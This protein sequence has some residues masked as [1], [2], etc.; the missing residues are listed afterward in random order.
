[1]AQIYIAYSYVRA[2]LFRE[3]RLLR[4]SDGGQSWS[5]APQVVSQPPPSTYY[6]GIPD[7]VVGPDH[8]VHVAWG[9]LGWWYW[10]DMSN[11]QGPNGFLRS[12][13]STDFG[14][15]W[16]L[17]ATISSYSS[18]YFSDGPMDVFGYNKSHVRLAVDRSSS[19]SRGNLYAT[20]TAAGY[21]HA[22]VGTGVVVNEVEPNNLPSGAQALMLGDDATGV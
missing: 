5:A 12:A 18:T 4:S 8:E 10:C 20:W 15:S 17:P 19:A 11:D 3:V 22:P 16:T 7:I 6:A 1:G 14:A 21:W 9:E 13:H 2:D